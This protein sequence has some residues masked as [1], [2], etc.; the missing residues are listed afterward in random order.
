MI[1]RGARGLLTHYYFYTPLRGAHVIQRGA[2]EL[3][4]HTRLRGAHVFQRGARGLLAK[5][6]HVFTFLSSLRGAH[7]NYAR[8]RGAPCICFAGCTC[9]G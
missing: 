1:Q 7:V 3:L 4:T 2:R 6:L 5:L 8:A 9:D